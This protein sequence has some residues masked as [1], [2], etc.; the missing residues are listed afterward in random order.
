MAGG[1]ITPLKRQL[2]TSSIKRLYGG[3]ILEQFCI[4]GVD[5][6]STKRLFNSVAADMLAGKT[7]AELKCKL[8]QLLVCYDLPPEERL[9]A[10]QLLRMSVTVLTAEQ[11]EYIKTLLDAQI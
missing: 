8:L 2:M 9:K 6:R 5:V 11:R 1:I 4:E 10:R 7:E 3:L